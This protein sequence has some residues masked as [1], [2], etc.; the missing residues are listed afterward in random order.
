MKVLILAGGYGTRLSEETGIRPKPMVEIGDMPI[1]WHIM[2]HYSAHGFNEFVILCGYKGNYIKKYFSDYFLNRSSMTFDMTTNSM[3]IIQS[4]VEPWKVTCLETGDGTMTGGRIKKAQDLIGNE[5][6]LLTYGD[7]VSDVDIESSI[8]S[9]KESGRLCT[10]TAVQPGGR[11]GV[12]QFDE[13][14]DQL[15]DFIEKPKGEAGW[16]NAGFFVCQPEVMNYIKDGDKTIFEKSPLQNLTKENQV[17]CYKH[18]GFW[19]CMDNLADKKTLVGLW[20]SG[21]AK[22]KTW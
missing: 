18:S 15:T 3:E 21:E 1:L 14:T 13:N 17:N 4:D 10:M 8:K 2:K 12:L 6:F 19:K 7:G 5:P 9:H 20:K 11:F 16:I 22:W